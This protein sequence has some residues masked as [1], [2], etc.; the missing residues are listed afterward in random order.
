MPMSIVHGKVRGPAGATFE[1][2]RVT[3]LF[4][5]KVALV[6]TA[7]PTPDVP[8]PVPAP[9]GPPPNGSDPSANGF[10]P[11]PAA[12]S[13]ATGEDGRFTLDVPPLDEIVEPIEIVVNGPSGVELARKPLVPTDL[14]KAV[15]VS[16][17]PEPAFPIRPSTDPT[18]GQRV[19]LQGRVIDER[20]RMVPAGLPVVIWGVPAEDGGE[21][22]DEDET[23][24][25]AVAR[26]VTDT[27]LGGYFAG[28]WPADDLAE[29]YGTVKGGPPLAIPLVEDRLPTQVV[30]VT[31]LDDDIF[32]DT[33]SCDDVPPRAP[34]PSDL[35]ANPAAFSQDLGGGCVD[36]TIPNRVLEEFAYFLAVRTS[37]PGIKGV[38]LD[39]P[40]PVPDSVRIKLAQAVEGAGGFG[41]RARLALGRAGDADEDADGV[42]AAEASATDAALTLDAATVRSLV[43]TDAA[44]SIVELENATFEAEVGHLRR[45]IDSFL[46]PAPA[47]APLDASHAVD[48]DDSP[49]VYQATTVAHGH[50]LQFREIWRADGY[51]LGDLKHSLPLAP[52]Q[53]RQI[54]VLDWDRRT[55]SSR[56]EALDSEERL[57]SVLARDRDVLEIVGSQLSQEESGSSRSTTWGVAGGIGAGFIG[58]GFGIFGGVAG[59][60]GGS[61]AESR[62]DSSRTLAANSLQQLSDRVNQRASAVRDT[63]S[64]VVQ[65]VAQGET[66]R[67]E[68][69]SIAN[70]N[71]CHALT[72]EY[73]EVL[74][75]FLVSHELVDARECLFV[76]LPMTRFDRAKALRWQE[77][78]RR[79]LRKPELAGGF[80]AM[81]RIARNWDG[82][83]F[84]E[85]RFSEE[86]PEVLEGEVRISFLLPRP[87]DAADGAFQ[88]DMWEPWGVLLP[89]DAL[90]LWTAKLNERTQADRDR[91]F[92]AE[93]APGIAEQL[94]QNLRF[95]Y[96]TETGAEIAVNL[97]ATL[98]SRYAESVPLY[99]SLRPAGTL[100]NLAREDIVR[101]EISY[102]GDDLPPDARV[103]VQSGKVRY[104]S[105]H[106]TYLLFD[107]PRLLNDLGKGD[108]VVVST[109]VSPREMRDP[110]EEDRQLADRLVK[111][112]NRNI[113]HYHQA[114]WATM[115]ASRRYM[116]L[117]GVIAPNADGRS[118]ASVVE[119]RLAGIVGNCLV[120]PVA[121][122]NQLDPGIAPP[123]PT[124]DG[125]E[126]EPVDLINRYATDPLPPSRLSVP[127]RGVYAEAVMGD[128]YACE[129]IDDRR[130]WRWGEEGG[131]TEALQPPTIE[132]VSTDTRD[133]GEPDL[134]PTPLP[135]PIVN[136]QA[137]PSLPDPLGLSAAFEVLKNP[138]LFKDITGLEGS[139]K[140]AL[141]AFSGS[142]DVASALGGEA[143]KLATQQEAA[144][145]ADRTLASITQAQQ[146]GLLTADQA[147]ALTEAALSRLVGQPSAT[148]ASQGNSAAAGEVLDGVVDAAVQSGQGEVTSSTPE[149]TVTVTFDGAPP[150]VGAASSMV[151]ID[152]P[153]PP[154]IKQSIITE[155]IVASGPSRSF[156]VTDRKR[157]KAAVLALKRID[158]GAG[159]VQHIGK[160]FFDHG[161]LVDDPA[162][163]SK[164]LVPLRLR[165]AYPES[166]VSAGTIAG[167]DRVPVVVLVHGNHA[168]W[169]PTT[170]GPP[171][172]TVTH[173]DSS[174][175]THTLDVLDTAT[176]MTDVPSFEGYAYLQEDLAKRGIVSVSVD[177]NFANRF[178]SRIETRADM[179]LAALDHMRALDKDAATRYF[180]R[181]DLSKVGL[182]GH[183][184]G[185]DAVVRVVEKNLGRSTTTRFGIE[186]VCSL[187]PT[188]ISGTATDTTRTQLSSADVGFFLGVWGTLD[189]DVSG[190]DG[191][192]NE[193]GNP[194]R[195]YE[196]TGAQKSMIHLDRC[197]HNR[198][199]TVW[200]GGSPAA[201]FS[202]DDPGLLAS[203]VPLLR[204]FA[205]HQQLAI[206][207]IGGMF[208]WHL[209]GDT[210]AR[211]LLQGTVAN[212]LAIPV[213]V[214]WSFGDRIRLLDTL[215]RAAPELPGATRTVFVG[216]RL[217]LADIEVTEDTITPGGSPATDVKITEHVG[218]RTGILE[219]DTSAATVDDRA[220]SLAVPAAQRNWSTD[221]DT[222]TF[223]LGALYAITSEA[224]LN[225]GRQPEAA[226]TLFDTAGKTATV[227]IAP[228]LTTPSPERPPFHQVDYEKASGG[229]SILNATLFRSET[230]RV[231]LDRF[232]GAPGIDLANVAQMLVKF[233]NANGT[234]V[235]FD[236]FALVK[237]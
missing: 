130:F 224:A 14:G 105:P 35:T 228:G 50:L 175:T 135:P 123:T 134:T 114:I 88:V 111:H 71:H 52:G 137:A 144:R 199:N 196:R 80:A 207:Y 25:A 62:Q 55:T 192:D 131:G 65:T 194:F 101:F 63:R 66:V 17:R 107:A 198:F 145:T 182:M 143:A 215:D 47:R 39:E 96:V 164:F 108:A 79:F 83:D 176:L 179:V 155:R 95:A 16:A 216:T 162:D 206:E 180:G 60:A 186:A 188:D 203:D 183:S 152:T 70:Y 64:T 133:E 129:Q 106:L 11:P 125:E 7:A 167:S 104:Q 121:P 229:A 197:E 110:R 173:V 89:T 102:E 37:E 54:A 86:A 204:S 76:P 19:R 136:V 100:P 73:F 184:R 31:T 84:P 159:T 165:I 157:T 142:L 77:P 94:V 202:G 146:D 112:L 72:I 18:L 235:L 141:A 43:R 15:V 160:T 23:V 116:L 127:T 40:T 8:V 237:E 213:S 223:R 82:Y 212:S 85:S 59:G 172:G 222:L 44:P 20:G 158:L 126:P 21:D 227:V 113:E 12:V 189:G 214:Q 218:A 185:G 4:H 193:F 139:Q 226:I 90:A 170:F 5:R 151:G 53:K 195:H 9:P 231:R 154:P 103:I 28:S 225:A 169:V 211:G 201:P 115:D 99:V 93:V 128:C 10:A 166:P 68:T 91:V 97:D 32:E 1:G 236:T 3:L 191:A 138:D 49:T 81:E 6:A 26:V 41:T 34:D 120:M 177:T 119:N 69:E 150:T 190:V 153:T 61:S 74:R 187:A 171:S 132:P 234:R 78:L 75:H 156:L 30:L 200:M 57:D 178:G 13:A 109:P 168:S 67:A 233:D 118:V 210:T 48:W 117:D 36:L 205:E 24:V 92:L 22:G 163:A 220:M 58:S 181:L 124:D 51:S 2:H 219:V 148:E 38:T 56:T 98:V 33:C 217:E 147:Q 221:V 174:G 46:R 122:G 209:L 232:G 87:R 161:L 149:Q 29:A 140:A 45:V 230:V 27:Q 42:V 208:A